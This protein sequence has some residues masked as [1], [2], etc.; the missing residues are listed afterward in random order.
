MKVK[1]GIMNKKYY[2]YEFVPFAL[3]IFAVSSLALHRLKPILSFENNLGLFIVG[4]VSI[5]ILGMYY[6]ILGRLYYVETGTKNK[7]YVVYF[8]VCCII[9][10]ISIFI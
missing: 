7:Y 4:A 6:H 5:I 9:F 10:V 2:K 3:W 8:L 1:G